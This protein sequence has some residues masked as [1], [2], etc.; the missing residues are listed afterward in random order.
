MFDK[1]IAYYEQHDD[2]V[3]VYNKDG[4][5]LCW[6]RGTLIKHTKNTVTIRPFWYEDGERLTSDSCEVY[7]VDGNK[8][9]VV[10]IPFV[11]IVENYE[12]E[13]EYTE[14]NIQSSSNSSEENDSFLFWCV[15]AGVLLLG[16]FSQYLR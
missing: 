16:I 15:V 5:N 3:N 6:H 8:V 12:P 11:P 13:I 9:G 10:S 1:T 4:E 7:D 2:M 14:P